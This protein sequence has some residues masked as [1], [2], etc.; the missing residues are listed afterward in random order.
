MVGT[1]I[2]LQSN[3]EGKLEFFI[4]YR[5]FLPIGEPIP[6]EKLREALERIINSLEKSEKNGVTEALRT[7]QEKMDAAGFGFAGY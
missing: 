5:A 1:K 6:K 2:T 4:L 3:V 7:A